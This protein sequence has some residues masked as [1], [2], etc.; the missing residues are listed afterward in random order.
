MAK[1]KELEE[2]YG[3]M[4]IKIMENG[5]LINHMAAERWKIN[6]AVGG[7]NSRMIRGK[8]MEHGKRLLMETDTSG[9]SVMISNTGM[10]YTDG[11][12][13]MYITESGNKIIEMDKDITGGQMALNTAETGRITRDRER[14]YSKITEYCTETNM[15][16]A[17]A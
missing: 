4:A 16:K 6:M 15:N 17:S 10:E 7:G 14:E 12:M 2:E 3:Q 11:L 1:E 9:N 8:D 5:I 13:E